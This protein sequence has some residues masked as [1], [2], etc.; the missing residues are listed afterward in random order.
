[1]SLCCRISPPMVNARTTVG[2][3]PCFQKLKP[4]RARTLTPQQ[5]RSSRVWTRSCVK[6]PHRL[7]SVTRIASIWRPCANARTFLRSIRSLRAPEADFSFGCHRRFLV[8][9]R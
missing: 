3:F 6:R 9:P 2:N 1:V 4:A 5:W 7:S 8:T